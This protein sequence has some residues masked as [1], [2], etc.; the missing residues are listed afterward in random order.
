MRPNACP[1]EV[2]SGS[3]TR[4]C[5]N[6]GIYGV[7]RSY[8]WIDSMKLIGSTARIRRV[9]K[10]ALCAVPTGRSNGRLRWNA[11]VGSLRLAL[12]R[13]NR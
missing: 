11:L 5:V 8:E 9:G 3:P 6:I 4:T 10:G 1:G 12:R 7:S 13:S 2:E